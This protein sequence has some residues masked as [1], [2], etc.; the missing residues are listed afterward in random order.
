MKALLAEHRQVT[1]FLAQ[2]L[3]DEGHIVDLV[4][5]GDAALERG[6]SGDHDVIILA[7]VLPKKGGVTVAAAL[8]RIGVSTPILLLTPN[9][10][11]AERAVR[12]AG[13]DA[14]LAKPFPFDVLLDVL[15]RLA[16]RPN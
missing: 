7:L 16:E 10:D 12:E 6:R 14:Y 13:A 5:D 4:F 11:G 2:G 1:G 9:H 15:H 3:Q 8:R